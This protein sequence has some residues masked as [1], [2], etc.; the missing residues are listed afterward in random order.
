VGLCTE[1]GARSFAGENESKKQIQ[2]SRIR[3][4]LDPQNIAYRS[5]ALYPLCTGKSPRRFTAISFR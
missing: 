5:P 4:V 2:C 3:P 1:K